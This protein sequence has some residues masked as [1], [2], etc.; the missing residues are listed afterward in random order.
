VRKLRLF[1]FVLSIFVFIF[2]SN[3]ISFA[4]DV[5]DEQWSAP[6]PKDVL[7]TPYIGYIADGIGAAPSS[8]DSWLL[9]QEADGSIPGTLYAIYLPFVIWGFISWLKI[10]KKEKIAL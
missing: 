7:T 2:S 1:S 6:L 5:P 10:S 9:G 3:S 4:A 8:G